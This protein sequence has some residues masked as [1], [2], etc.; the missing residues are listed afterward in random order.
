MTPEQ[1]RAFLRSYLD[2]TDGTDVDV[3]DYLDA[4]DGHEVDP[5]APDDEVDEA[6]LAIRVLLRDRDRSHRD[7]GQPSATHWLVG[8]L[9]V[10]LDPHGDLHLDG[11]PGADGWTPCS[12]SCESEVR[13]DE[14]DLADPTQDR[15][16]GFDFL[17]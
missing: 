10:V 12:F 9:Q 11:C 8:G 13:A 14:I 7:P 17:P 15:P 2:D 4:V 16:P 6:S 3:D 5:D 1:A